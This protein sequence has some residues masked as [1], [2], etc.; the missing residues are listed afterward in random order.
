MTEEEHKKK[1]GRTVKGK[2]EVRRRRK[3]QEGLRSA[4]KD[5]GG[6]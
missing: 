5:E 6:E 4:E 2:G 1:L 3:E